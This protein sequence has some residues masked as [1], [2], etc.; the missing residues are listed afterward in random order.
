MWIQSVVLEYHCDISVL[1]LYIVYNSVADLQSTGRDIFQTCDHTKG[2]RL[3]TSGG[4]YED[5][6]FLVFDFQI[7]I[8]NCFK[9]IGI[10]FGD[11]L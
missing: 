5:D 10:N 11:V 9:T 7:E 6:E 1:G 4:T 8:L 3:T 2:S